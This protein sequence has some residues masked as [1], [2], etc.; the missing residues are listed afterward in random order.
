MLEAQVC[1]LILYFTVANMYIRG[2]VVPA[3]GNG[4]LV[5]IR[6]GSLLGRPHVLQD[7]GMLRGIRAPH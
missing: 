1:L 4:R 5:R 7:L 6:F 3:D 2:A